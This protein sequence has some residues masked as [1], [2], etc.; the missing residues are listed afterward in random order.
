MAIKCNKGK[1]PRF[2][3]VDRMRNHLTSWVT[4]MGKTGFLPYSW[5]DDRGTTVPLPF[6]RVLFGGSVH[7]AIMLSLSGWFCFRSYNGFMDDTWSTLSRGRLGIIT[8]L[9]LMAV[10][11]FVDVRWKA[12]QCAAVFRELSR[13]SENAQGKCAIVRFFLPRTL[14]V[15]QISDFSDN[16]MFSHSQNQ[17][18]L[19]SRPVR[20]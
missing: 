12:A 1:R 8:L 3:D 19:T 13:M 4:F 6:W 11:T 17:A 16:V 18:L 7:L 15:V 20:C 5:D 2:N 14:L 10:A 9:V